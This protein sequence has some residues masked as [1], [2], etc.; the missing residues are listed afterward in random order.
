MNTHSLFGPFCHFAIPRRTSVTLVALFT[1]VGEVNASNILGRVRGS[2]HAAVDDA[3]VM[4]YGYVSVGTGD[5]KR[6][7]ERRTRV[8]TDGDFVF[9]DLV[10]GRYAI[11]ASAPGFRKYK[12]WVDLQIDKD[13]RVDIKLEDPSTWE[14]GSLSTFSPTSNSIENV[15]DFFRALKDAS[16]KA[17]N[18][19]GRESH[20]TLVADVN[21]GMAIGFL[22]SEDQDDRLRYV[23][24]GAKIII[25]RAFKKAADVLLPDK[26]AVYV[27]SISMRP[28]KLEHATVESKPSPLPIVMGGRLL[29]QNFYWEIK[30]IAGFT[31]ADIYLSG[32]I[33]Y[34]PS[35][36][37]K[38]SNNPSRT[39]SLDVP[40]S[41]V[42]FA[43]QPTPWLND[44][45]QLLEVL[46][47]LFGVVG[48]LPTLVLAYLGLRK[49]WKSPE[50]P[51]TA[52]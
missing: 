25:K 28:D 17:I 18:K 42:K 16:V 43:T 48:A 32:E 37:A 8:S 23:S 45:S 35:E 52:S 12:C 21:T 11:E 39:D 31:A 24:S 34:Y 22:E 49:I 38:K 4:L 50:T 15:N 26:Q 3:V 44:L 46:M 5:R 1:L 29:D 20:K 14:Y 13:L 40:G 2:S 33:N 41:H 30:P 36:S 7:I 51:P 10:P 6:L 47:K 27:L 9:M 19:A